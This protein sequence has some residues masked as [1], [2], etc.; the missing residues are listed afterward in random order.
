MER[1]PPKR[2]KLSEYT[3]EE[4]I[5]SVKEKIDTINEQYKRIKE[6]ESLFK[7]KMV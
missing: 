6:L 1:V 2:K 3:K 5:E 4:L 7:I